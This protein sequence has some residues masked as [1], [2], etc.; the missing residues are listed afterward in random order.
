MVMTCLIFLPVAGIA[1][2]RTSV[3]WP[4][5]GD[6]M[7]KVHCEFLE[8]AVD[9]NVWDFSGLR[10]TG[11]RHDVRWLNYGDSLLAR[12]E[13]GGQVTYRCN[14][15]SV[16][17]ISTE[18]KLIRLSAAGL[19]AQIWPESCTRDNM[20]KSKRYEGFFSGE[21]EVNTNSLFNVTVLGRGSLI[22]PTDTLYDVTRIRFEVT[23]T[24]N[25]TPGFIDTDIMG[26][27][28]GEPDDTLAFTADS[29][30][31]SVIKD[32]WYSGFYR[33]EIVENTVET[34]TWAGKDITIRRTTCLMSPDA[35][36]YQLGILKKRPRKVEEPLNF[37]PDRPNGNVSLAEDINISY[38]GSEVSVDLSTASSN[39]TTNEMSLLLYD[40]AGRVWH[41]ARNV[42][43][44]GC[45]TYS[46]DTRW[47][48]SGNYIVTVTG[49]SGN[50]SYKFTID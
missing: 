40:S 3:H 15:D 29:L 30:L 23:E 5:H 8:V 4:V 19:R 20:W 13:N 28:L 33:Y 49:G 38:N 26:G 44:E 7:E 45:R 1:G 50:R 31:H 36:E 16:F 24:L 27:A 48:P 47:L 2:L 9:T 35:Q 41:K 39:A 11:L 17:L 6:R 14:R 18:D 21:S 10:E 42:I 22:L 37:H 12:I 25:V 32:R 34:Y 43:Q 46:V